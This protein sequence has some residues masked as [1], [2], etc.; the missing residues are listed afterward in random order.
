MSPCSRVEFGHSSFVD[1]LLDATYLGAAFSASLNG[2]ALA[3]PRAQ[4]A[5]I[6]AATEEHST[7]SP[8]I[9]GPDPLPHDLVVSG[10]GPAAVGKIR[11]SVFVLPC[12]PLN[13]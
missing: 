13:D 3:I 12:W 11:A 6:A 9:Y 1:A 2:A 10:E 4:H 7:G 5:L 8:R